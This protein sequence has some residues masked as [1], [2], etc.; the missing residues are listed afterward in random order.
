MIYE[1]KNERITVASDGSHRIYEC[2]FHDLHKD[3]DKGGAVIVDNENCHFYCYDTLFHYCSAKQSGGIHIT[4]SANV[5]CSKICALSCSNTYNYAYFSY[6]KSSMNMVCTFFST[7]FCKGNASTVRFFSKEVTVSNINSTNNEGIQEPSF[8]LS[9]FDNAFL[10]Y[11]NSVSNIGYS[12][13]MNLYNGKN[14]K[15]D[16]IHYENCTITFQG[17]D[18]VPSHIKIH[19]VQGEV[20]LSNAYIYVD[21]DSSGVA[22]LSQEST[23]I[24]ENIY[25]VGS[26]KITGTIKSSNNVIITSEQ[27]KTLH[28]SFL[29][30]KLCQ[31]QDLICRILNENNRNKS[32]LPVVVLFFVFQ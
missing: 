5:M 9:N 15:V 6:L 19:K 30:T 21:A 1:Y 4:N 10:Q 20:K 7:H 31:I 29:N 26:D 16:R 32:N 23:S 11:A 2:T 25:M 8:L 24:L 22:I 3:N 18:Y 28:F 13:V 17:E 27:T 12:I 14:A